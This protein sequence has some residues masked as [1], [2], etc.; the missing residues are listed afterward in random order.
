M[1]EQTYEVQYETGKAPIKM[2]TKG[3]AVEDGAKFRLMLLDGRLGPERGS[4][5]C[6]R[7]YVGRSREADAE[8]GSD[9]HF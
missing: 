9:R 8:R 2:W 7:S 5:R 3:V 6:Q 1:T 4:Q